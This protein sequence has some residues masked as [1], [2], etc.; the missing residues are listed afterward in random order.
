VIRVRGALVPLLLLVA[1]AVV[2]WSA[3]IDRGWI[4]R[5]YANDIYAA[6]ATTFVPLIDRLPFAAGDVLIVGVAGGWLAFVISRARARGRRATVPILAGTL[7]LAAALAVWFQGAW[8]L[9]Y[10]R[11]PIAG[12]VDYERTRVTDAAVAAY[13]RTLVAGLN[14]TAPAAHAEMQRAPQVDEAT[15]ER[16]FQPV[17]ARLGDTYPVRVSEPKTS[18]LLDRWFA[19]AGIGGMF[20]PFAYETILNSEFLPFERPFALAHEWGHVAGFTAEG[21]ANL[22]AALTCLRS[23]DPLIHYSGLIWTYDYFPRD[24]VQAYRLSRLVQDDQRSAQARFLQHYDPR[25]YA[26]QW[27]AYDTYLRANRV[28]S[29]VRSYGEFT[30]LLVGTP[31]DAQGLP[32]THAF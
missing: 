18:L 1:A 7:G 12:R 20:D 5:G 6:L 16:D 25:V 26:L 32:R 27:K 17:V 22:I 3:P 19:I 30:A 4:E 9:N 24:V 15:L 28:A 14:A 21:D 2:L 8:G 23:H 10:R 13:A 29:G 31:L 11:V